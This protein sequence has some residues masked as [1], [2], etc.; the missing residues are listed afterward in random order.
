MKLYHWHI[1]CYELNHVVVMAPDLEE[2]QYLAIRELRNRNI[3]GFFEE[4]R[5][6]IPEVLEYPKSVVLGDCNE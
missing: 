5:N 6:S 1:G 3:T 4:I 2:A